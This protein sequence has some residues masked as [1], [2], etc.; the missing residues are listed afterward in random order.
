MSITIVV[1]G[2]L[3]FFSL[4]Y[5]NLFCEPHD[6]LTVLPVLGALRSPAAANNRLFTM[7][8]GG[9]PI[10]MRASQLVKAGSTGLMDVQQTHGIAGR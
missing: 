3:F 8:Q 6:R 4:V 1:E 10:E 5:F 2:F 9:I 7:V